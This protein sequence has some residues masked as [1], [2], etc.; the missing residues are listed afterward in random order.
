[1]SNVVRFGVRDKNDNRIDDPDF[2]GYIS[3]VAFN[4]KLYKLRCEDRKSTRLNSSHVR[5]SRMPSSA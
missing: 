1:M 3:Q 2:D 5:Q 4:G